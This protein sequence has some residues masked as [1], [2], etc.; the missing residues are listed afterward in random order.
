LD[1]LLSE[2]TRPDGQ[3]I[4]F[5]YTQAAGKYHL[6][7][8]EDPD[9]R[10]TTYYYN[11]SAN[12]LLKD[13]VYPTGA[14][15][16]YECAKD[17]TS[18]TECF[19]WFVTKETL[20]NKSS[21]ELIR[22]TSVDYKIINGR[23]TFAKLTQK[24]EN[25]A[26][27]GYTEYVFR[28][29]LRYTGETK[30]NSTGVQMYSKLT[31]YDSYGQ[32]ARIDT[33]KG[34]SKSVDYSEYMN[35][36]DWG[37]VIFTRDALGHSVYSSYVNT[38]TQNSFQGGDIL[39]RSSSGKIFYDAFDD[40]DF[41][42]W[43]Q[44]MTGSC[45][46]ALDA[47]KDPPHA[48]ALKLNRATGSNK[49]CKIDN[50]FISQTGDFYFQSSFLTST[51]AGY[52]YSY[53]CLC[54]GAT[55]RILFSARSD[56]NGNWNFY[57]WSGSQYV[58]LKSCAINTWYDIGFFAR[59]NN[60]YDIYI[61]GSCVKKYAPMINSG[62][63]NTI[64]Y[65]EGDY[66]S[67]S[68][69]TVYID[70]IRIYKSL[71]VTVNNLNSKYMAEL[72]DGSGCLL[73]MSKNGT[74][75][76][77]KMQLNT[78][79]GYIRIWK[80]GD[81]SF[82]TPMM[83][84]WG[85][86]VY[87]FNPGLSKSNL[88]K[89]FSSY[90]V[91]CDASAFVDDGWPTESIYYES[92][93]GEGS[94]VNDSGA[95]VSGNKYHVS[96][97]GPSDFP[98]GIH[99]HGFNN[100][101]LDHSMTISYAHT[102]KTYVWLSYGMVPKEIMLQF[103]VYDY[104]SQQMGWRRAY[105][106]GDDATGADL[107]GNLQNGF[108]PRTNI[109]MGDVPQITGKWIELSV[110][111]SDLG[112]SWIN[113]Q[114]TGVI[115][116][117]YGGTAKWDFT[118]NYVD[119][120]NIWY[121]PI[122]STVQ[123]AFD[124]GPTV[125]K[126]VTGTVTC[127]DHQTSGMTTWPNSGYF[128]IL[129]STS[130][131][132]Y[133]S[134]HITDIYNGDRFEYSTPEFYPNEI[135]PF[136]HNRLAGTFQCQD[137]ANTTSEENYI[138]YDIEGNA[139]E[140]KS[141][142][143][144][145]W[146][147]SQSGFDQYGNQLWSS[148]PTGRL[149]L[150]EY[151]SSNNY[152]YPV[153]TSSGGHRDV[154]EFDN[155]WNSYTSGYELKAQYTTD[156]S[157]SP[158]HSIEISFSNCGGSGSSSMSK[159]FV[160]NPLSTLSVQM[161]LASFYHN[162]GRGEYMDSGI[163]MTLWGLSTQD[164]WLGTP[165]VYYYYLACWQQ[166]LDNRTGT[167]S[168]VK[169]IFGKPDMNK[170]MNVAVHPYSDW[171]DINWSMVEKVT[172]SLYVYVNNGCLDTFK[173]Y[174]DDFT[175]DDFALNS[176]T[177]YS[178][179]KKTGNLLS[180]T[181]PLVH[182]TST[183]YDV[184]GRVVRTNDSDGNY[185]TVTYDDMNNKVTFFDELN[186]K[187]VKY[188]DGIGRMIKVQRFNGSALYSTEY[189]A[190][191]WQDKILTYKDA[192]G[193]ITRNYYDFL[194][195]PIKTVNP[196][197]TF[198]TISYNDLANTVTSIDENGNKIARIYDDLGRLNK[199]K[200]Y[201]S[202]TT[203]SFQDNGGGLLKAYDT[204]GWYYCWSATTA[205]MSDNSVGAVGYQ[206]APPI[207]RL[208]RTAQMFDTSSLPDNCI[209]TGAYIAISVYHQD[210]GTFDIVVQHNSTNSRPSIPLS[211]SD[212]NKN[213]YTD[214]VGSIA[215]SAVALGWN[216][217]YLNPTGFNSINKSGM[218]KF[219]LR[220]SFDIDNQSQANSEYIAWQ[221][222]AQ[223]DSRP[224]LY[225][226]Y[227]LPND[228]SSNYETKMSYDAASNLVNVA[229]SNGNV[230]R[231]NYDTLNGLTQTT[232][233]D[234]LSESAI[235]DEGGRVIN[236]TARSG[237]TTIPSYDSSGRLIK[238]V[239]LNDTISYLFDA[240]GKTVKSS[241]SLGAFYYI[242]NDRD[243][244]TSVSENI[245]GSN[246]TVVYQFDREGKLVNL[247]YPNSVKITYGYDVFDRMITVERNGTSRLLTIEYDSED[248]VIKETTGGGQVTDYSYNS[249]GWV[250]KLETRNAGQIVLS[251]N[252]TY[253]GV[254]N[255]KSIN[256]RPGVTEYYYYDALDR[257]INAQGQNTWGTSIS[258]GYD[259][260][261]N[262]QWESDGRI[263]TSYTYGG[264]S[265]LVKDVF[266]DYTYNDN[267]DLI[268]KQAASNNTRYNYSF[269]S[270]GQMMDAYKYVDETRTTIGSYF[271]DA[272]GARAKTVERSVTTEYVYSGH[273]PVCEK[274][275]GRYTNYV[276]A[277]GHMK[278]KIKGNDV[279]YYIDDVLGSTRLVYNGSTQAFKV[280]AY[281]PF[282]EACGVSGSEK[283]T[284][285]GETKDATGLFYLGARY[286]DPAIGRFI[287]IDPEK[288]KLSSPQT[289]NGY[290]YCLNDPL[291]LTDPTG[292]HPPTG[293]AGTIEWQEDSQLY[294]DENDRDMHFFEASLFHNFGSIV[295][296][297]IYGVGDFY[298]N[299]YGGIV[300]FGKATDIGVGL[301]ACI[302]TGYTQLFAAT[303]FALRGQQTGDSGYYIVAA[304][305]LLSF[306]LLN[307]GELSAAG[308]AIW[309]TLEEGGTRAIDS[310]DS[311][312]EFAF[313]CGKTGFGE[314]SLAWNTAES[315]LG[316]DNMY[317]LL[318]IAMTIFDWERSPEANGGSNG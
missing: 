156:K 72:Y 205:N 309:N 44:T 191:N 272:N 8:T 61:D 149:S 299:G 30:K 200:E 53:I 102:L 257:L 63:I 65:W 201:Y 161:Y 267:G 241:N 202:S 68:I 240:D 75:S 305:C 254:G 261:G 104:Q 114:V 218:T 42:D 43:T 59:G 125:S 269:N 55:I 230:T 154:F 291:I 7:Q 242:Y 174:Y 51:N 256:Y 176:T 296:P 273:D 99:W 172:F 79:P 36:D 50:S 124:D 217:I 266:W 9:N 94:W 169:V 284:F 117:L 258:Y 318:E 111:A 212:Y 227:S 132:L 314:A 122:G 48:P 182:I 294:T 173:V 232:Y 141:K 84:I 216:N 221:N 15:T 19:S 271:Y 187:T 150:T 302:P 24:D 194:G 33:M 23:V 215:N 87:N 180:S 22:S 236:K 283:Y 226:T 37:N 77:Q 204:R 253:D 90:G 31:Y 231:M 303:Y 121:A 113:N 300:D 131:L 118:D 162:N 181:D 259:S 136:I 317:T 45:Y 208:L 263:T 119:G 46:A 278:V 4:E 213:F 5:T 234:G 86:D 138:K 137:V 151:S 17:G 76:I 203:L 235:Y 279:Y 251:M 60:S 282:G 41:S 199:T 103:Y 112:I 105:W 153:S 277:N 223:S 214:C 197:G 246:N 1:G 108:A 244:E 237:Q 29:Y 116:G 209:I 189:Y 6:W 311:L 306:G 3:T 66:A 2:I 89:T 49:Y 288:G 25:N 133:A 73:A 134:P 39:T 155:S 20:R 143:G 250:T 96:N 115:Y 38:S 139:N 260:V 207:V 224:K 238:I 183:Q 316:P 127:I 146:V 298:D 243:Q 219:M 220:A 14:K 109:R 128:K 78:P 252:Y 304:G 262:R 74:L 140:T 157:Y 268:C 289:L 248:A 13:I 85:G 255:V 83:D 310:L 57:Y 144:S 177:T 315:I 32:P 188:F 101:P 21:G 129:N 91:G 67:Y 233:P 148:D 245:A 135:K 185:S 290:V 71:T 206:P 192:S 81:Y 165:D 164:P 168:N 26:V 158:T 110:L 196:D 107:M 98:T 190:Y 145:G 166:N 229:A 198:R 11:M 175:Y 312:G 184:L 170:W 308:K 69:I 93:T 18:S 47:T 64:S 56:S 54:S 97:Y 80:I 249:R 265:K 210:T 264:Y 40:W 228:Y 16:S 12:Y 247:T 225:I 130:S 178:F 270:L 193:N 82:S 147:Y 186:H 163:K 152:T 195:R 313:Q 171:P 301:A 142:L 286:Y 285:A 280:S 276:L 120:I 275:N 239:S 287:S 58:S 95:T 126:I 179:N 281:K 27:A 295:G 159:D 10:I 160:V 88:N 28:S 70:N 292:L 307:Y 167:P 123:F 92:R 211:N 222:S 274:L 52:S 34:T 100:T 35:Y 106:G 293:P 297:I 62:N